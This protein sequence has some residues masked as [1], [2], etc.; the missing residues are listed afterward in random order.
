MDPTQQLQAEPFEH[1]ASHHVLA[2]NIGVSGNLFGGTMLCWVDEAAAL[3]A[4]RVARNTFVTYEMEKV[5]FLR[6]CH[7]GDI[8]DIA[9]RLFQVRRCGLDLELKAERLNRS[10][11]TRE[12]VLTTRVVMVAIGADGGKTD[13]NMR[14]EGRGSVDL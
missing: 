5:R 10:E 7:T 14:A 13:V 9:A 1:I 2:M 6:P 3:F 8:V 11:G 12:L 4:D